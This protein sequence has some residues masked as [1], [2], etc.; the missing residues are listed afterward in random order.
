MLAEGPVGHDRGDR[1][2]GAADLLLV[3][4]VDA[5]LQVQWAESGEAVE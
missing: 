4:L 2:V 5:V 1:V 3:V